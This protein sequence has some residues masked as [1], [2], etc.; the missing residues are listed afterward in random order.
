MATSPF[1]QA[2]TPKLP[3]LACKGVITEVPEAKLTASEDYYMIRVKIQG[4]DGSKDVTVNFLFRPE[5]LTPGFDPVS[6]ETLINSSEPEVAKRGRAFDTVYRNN[7]GG[8]NSQISHLKGFCGANDEALNKFGELRDALYAK[9]NAGKTAED[10]ED[11]TGDE[12]QGLLS[13][14]VMQVQGSKV[15]GYVL[16]QA[17]QKTDEMDDNDKPVYELRSNYEVKNYYLPSEK[18][19][20]SFVKRAKAAVPA[21]S[22]KIAYQA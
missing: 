8:S 22:F 3:E 10:A 19:H 16:K 7:V 6:F 1:A 18:M 21:G 14:F 20:A 13:K 5:W 4:I 9:K 12:I 11:L 2:K 17:T 15:L